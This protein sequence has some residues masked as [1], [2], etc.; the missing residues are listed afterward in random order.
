M[1]A[2]SPTPRGS[3]RAPYHSSF[4]DFPVSA[5]AG[6]I[7]QKWLVVTPF[8]GTVAPSHDH[9][10]WA[11]SAV[12]RDLHEL[13]SRSVLG[14]VVGPDH[15]PVCSSAVATRARL[16]P[17]C[18]RHLAQPKQLS[19]LTRLG[20]FVKPEFRILGFVAR[21]PAHARRH[22][23]SRGWRPAGSSAPASRS[24]SPVTTLLN[25]GLGPGPSLIAD[26]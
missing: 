15:C 2:R 20:Y 11:R 26:S 25:A 17:T 23:S 9:Q 18:P 8:V 13:Q 6:N 22:R 1:R 10:Y 19:D 3:T 7:S 21:G 5:P 12:G 4:Q 14:R 16:C 24:R